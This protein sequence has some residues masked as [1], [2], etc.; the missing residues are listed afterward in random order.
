M[1]EHRAVIYRNGQGMV[2]RLLLQATAETVDR[3]MV[4][5][6]SECLGTVLDMLKEGERAR[7]RSKWQVSADAAA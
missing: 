6:L 1:T 7:P 2:S 4:I 5:I 3:D